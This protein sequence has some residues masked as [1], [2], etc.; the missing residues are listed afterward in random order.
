METLIY[1]HNVAISGDH[2]YATA[3]RPGLNVISMSDPTNPWVMSSMSVLEN[4]GD[5]VASRHHVYFT[6]SSVGL[7]VV[8]VQDPFRLRNSGGCAM[9][10]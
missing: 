9:D 8:D 5:V 7:H 6:N 2:A 10:W 3:S 4:A 1:A